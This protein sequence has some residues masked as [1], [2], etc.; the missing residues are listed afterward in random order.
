[1]DATQLGTG[2]FGVCA[3]FWAAL[4]THLTQK[5]QK[6][7]N[8]VSAKATENT[9]AAAVSKQYAD[10]VAKLEKRLEDWTKRYDAADIEWRVR[11]DRMHDEQ[12]KDRE[13]HEKD[14]D[15]WHK[16]AE[17]DNAKQLILQEENTTLKARTDL[18]PLIEVLANMRQDRA[19]DLS[20]RQR[21]LETLNSFSEAVN[22][23]HERFDKIESK[24]K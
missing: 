17:V 11:Y 21:M 12:Q 6:E 4:Q 7:L 3:A 1:M 13:Q 23:I 14:R 24:Q 20:L 16:K 9:E 2:I 15:H 18:Q 8:Q 5:K 19:E 22:R 10:T